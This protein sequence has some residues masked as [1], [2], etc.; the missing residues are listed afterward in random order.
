VAAGLPALTHASTRF[1][2]EFDAVKRDQ[3]S[4]WRSKVLLQCSRNLKGP[5]SERYFHQ[6]FRNIL[7]RCLSH[8]SSLSHDEHQ[9]TLGKNQ[10]TGRTWLK[11]KK[12]SANRTHDRNF[13]TVLHRDLDFHN[14]KTGKYMLISTSLWLSP[15][16]LLDPRSI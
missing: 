12:K 13:M 3:I 11:K 5:N 2:S 8:S 15:K 14:R 16:P 4:H 7:H 9:A 6:I 10:R 1:Q